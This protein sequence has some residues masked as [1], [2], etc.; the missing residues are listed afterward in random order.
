MYVVEELFSGVLC[1]N[2]VNGSTKGERDLVFL[3]ML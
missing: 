3:L 1:F 2:V